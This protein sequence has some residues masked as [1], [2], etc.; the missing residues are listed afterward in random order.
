MAVMSEANDW[1]LPSS[2]SPLS[3][4][5]PSPDYGRLQ[6]SPGPCYFSATIDTSLCLPPTLAHLPSTQA[7]DASSFLYVVPVLF[8]G[9]AVTFFNAFWL[10][11]FFGS[12]PEALLG[13]SH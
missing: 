11:F 1:V 7:R 5:R 3:F 4:I 13:P 6:I 8:L 9:Y 10:S 12:L 2:H